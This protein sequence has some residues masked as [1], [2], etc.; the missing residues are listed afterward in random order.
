MAQRVTD[1]VESMLGR[2][3]TVCRTADEALV[4]GNA[5]P[6]AVRAHLVGQGLA[7]QAAER[8]VGLYGD[9][10][11]GLTAGPES[12]AA[13]AVL[14]EGAL[15]L[16]DY[17]VR[18]SARAWFDLDGG[19]AAL[20]AAAQAMAPLLGWSSDRANDEIARCCGLRETDMAALANP[21][22]RQAAPGELGPVL[23]PG[24]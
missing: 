21:S 13:H 17:W 1:K 11:V 3:P 18:R 22:A 15:T 10:A 16:E 9:E 20:P 14:H 4:G 19:L 12:E 6:V 7:D 24:K 8:L 23:T 5:E 2:T